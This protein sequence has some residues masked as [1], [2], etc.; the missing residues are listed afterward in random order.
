MHTYKLFYTP[1]NHKHNDLIN[2]SSDTFFWIMF[3]VIQNHN[4]LNRFHID[5]CWKMLNL[6]DCD[7]DNKFP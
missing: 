1:E 4:L 6:F 2:R 5:R 3:I 7:T